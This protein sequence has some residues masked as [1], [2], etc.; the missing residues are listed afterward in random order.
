MKPDW[1]IERFFLIVGLVLL[2][3]SVVVRVDGLVMSRA[4]IWSFEAHQSEPPSADPTIGKPESSSLNFSLWSEK[5]VNA[6]KAALGMKLEAPLAVLSIPRI[7]VEVPVFDGTDELILNRGAGRIAGTAKPGQS[8]NIGIA[9]HRDGFF[10]S[11]KD[12]RVGD[13]VELRSQS[14]EFLYAV[15]DIEI[16]QPT[17]VSV[18]R[19]RPSPSLTLVTCYPFYFVGDAPQRYIVHA[20]IV[21]SD[22]TTTSKLNSAVQKEKEHTQ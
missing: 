11:L 1:R 7:G 9:A 10:R 19:N 21:D 20:S 14:N 15:D 22:K 13:R 5:R 16:V 2:L 4:A 12:I 17:D 3:V 8:G 18:L 6:Y